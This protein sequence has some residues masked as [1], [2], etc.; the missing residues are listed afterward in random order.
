MDAQATF[1]IVAQQF[2]E[3]ALLESTKALLEWDERTG[4]PAQAGG[5]RAAQIT[6]LSGLIHRRKTQPQLGEQLESLSDSELASD[7]HSAPGATIA[8]LLKDYRRNTRLPVELVEA[9]STATVLGQQAWERARAADHW[10]TFAPH[11]QEI[12]SLR[13][14]EAE[15]LRQDGEP[16]YDTLLDQ[17]EEGAR[18]KA[19]TATFASLRDELVCLV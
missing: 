8:R 14:Q 7:P 9:L 4:L 11:L 3:I 13:R 18:S 19:L 10:K 17:Y 5:Y 15:F 2:R 12:F 16:L 1:D 6:L